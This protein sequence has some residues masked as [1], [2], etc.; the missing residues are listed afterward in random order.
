MPEQPVAQDLVLWAG[1]V[2]K[3][4]HLQGALGQPCSQNTWDGSACVPGVGNNEI[5]QGRCPQASV[6]ASDP[7]AQASIPRREI[8]PLSGCSGSLQPRQRCWAGELGGAAGRAGTSVHLAA[9]IR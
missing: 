1:S 2:L 7:R 3:L 6:D 5:D 9:E 4:R 8:L